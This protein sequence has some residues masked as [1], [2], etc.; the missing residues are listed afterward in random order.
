MSAFIVVALS[1]SSLNLSAQGGPWEGKYWNNRN[2]SGNPVLVRQD[3]SINFDWGDGSPAPQ[4]YTDNFSV[5]WTQ[6][7]NLPAGTYR[8]SATTDDGMRVWVDNVMIIDSWFDSQ[9][10]TV[11][12]DVYLGAGNHTIVV[13][14][15]EAGGVAVARMNYV[16][17]G[18]QTP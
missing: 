2:L 12:A 11:S 14:Y 5:Q 1:S 4:V 6:T 17:V 13:Q 9:A 15:Y 8:F 18:G 10:H 16:Q 3:G 7:A